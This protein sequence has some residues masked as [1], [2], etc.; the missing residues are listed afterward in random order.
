MS[1]PI[2]KQVTTDSGSDVLLGAAKKRSQVSSGGLLP[3]INLGVWKGKKKK[4]CIWKP[5][6]NIFLGEGHTG[7]S[8]FSVVKRTKKKEKKEK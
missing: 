8:C 7:T 1:F 2:I 4:E 6:K 5:S 3:R